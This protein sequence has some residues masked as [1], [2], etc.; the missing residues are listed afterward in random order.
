VVTCAIP[1][2]YSS[3]KSAMV[4]SCSAFNPP[5]GILMRCMPG[6]SHMVLGPLVSVPEGYSI[7]WT[8][9][10]IVP[11]AVVVA[12]AVS[13]AAQARFGEQALFELALLAQAISI[14]NVSISRAKASGIFPERRCAHDEFEAFI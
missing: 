11:L 8:D 13:A 12:L 1:S 3:A 6:A 14:S 9:F 2:E 10:A 7:S 4:S 5:A